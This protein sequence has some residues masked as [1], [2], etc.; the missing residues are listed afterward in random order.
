VAMRRYGLRLWMACCLLGASGGVGPAVLYAETRTAADLTPEAVWA[1]IESAQDGDTVQLPAGKAV[2]EKGWNTGHGAP[3][4]AI[5]IQGAGID[6]TIIE[7]GRPEPGGA[8]FSIVGVEGK[9][10]RVTG[11]T[12]DGTG[13]E[14]AG[15]W[16]GFVRVRGDCKKF[17]IDHCKFINA[18]C[19]LDISGDTLGLIDH[20]IFQGLE[21]HGGNVQPINFSGPGEANYRKPLSL[22]TADATFFEDNE[23]YIAPFAGTRGTRTGNNPWIAPNNCSRI[24]V[25]HNKLVNSQLEIYA[26]GRNKQYGSQQC[27]I[28]DNEFPSEGEGRPQ[29]SIFIASGVAMVF[30]NTVTGPRNWRVILLSNHRAYY[31]MGNSPFGKADGTNPYD[32]NEIPAG[33]VGAG[34]PCMGQVGRGTDLDRDGIY[35]P[36]PCYAWNN[37]IDGKPML[38]AVSRRDANETAQIVEGRDFFNHKPPEGSYTPYVYPHPLQDEK[39]WEDLMKTAAEREANRSAAAPVNKP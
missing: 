39:A 21:S 6:K 30:N 4:K 12:I 26:P 33:Q 18:D 31:V 13:Y 8:P 15:R 10:F 24:V 2:W 38:M 5:T 9:P 25:R 17:R 3:M 11:I 28:Y 36:T 7:D 37:T 20:C 29:G 19:M 27:E 14:N 16:G 23:V 22:G 35:E 34:Y 1:A 32:G